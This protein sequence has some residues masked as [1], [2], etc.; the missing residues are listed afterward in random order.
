MKITL[1]KSK[2]DYDFN[3]ILISMKRNNY[4]KLNK[5][6]YGLKKDKEKLEIIFW[7]VVR[8]KF[9]P[10][11]FKVIHIDDNEFSF[12]QFLLV[13]IFKSKNILTIRLIDILN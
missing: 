1:T 9:L 7:N 13:R 4:L 8:K 12:Y 6:F 2:H 5:K 10:L 3:K 11:V